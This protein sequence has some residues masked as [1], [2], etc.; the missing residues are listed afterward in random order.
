MN[1]VRRG[2]GKPLLLLHGIGGSWRSWQTVL[3][4]LARAREVIA[5]DL[6]GFGNTPPLTGPVTISTLADAVTDFLEAHGLLGIDAVGSSMGARLVLEL[7]RRGG[8]LGAVVSLDPGGFWK[9][10]EIPVFYHSV[11]LSTKL[12]RALQPAMPFLTGNAG[13]RTLLFAQFSAHP[14]QV[15]APVALDEMRSFAHSPSFDE[16]LGNLAYGEEQQGA[17]KGSISSPL[18]IGWGRQDRVCFPGQAKRALKKFPDARL[19]WFEQCGHF[20]QWDQ[21]AETIRLIL[22]ATAGEAF[23]DVDIARPVVST[24]PATR[25][26]QGAVAAGVA[27]LVLGGIWLLA[28]KPSGGA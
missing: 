8:V 21:P 4:D 6:P 3:D 14:W 27:A 18:V 17:A 13:T 10:W 9:G 23:R 2:A 26:S 25:V 24:A 12:V 11:A 16:L 28:R 20:P 19:Y 7:A 22:A 15:P 1:Y 5:V